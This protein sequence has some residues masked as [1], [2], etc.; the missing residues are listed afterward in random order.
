VSETAGLSKDNV[1]TE[2]PRVTTTVSRPGDGQR[3]PIAHRLQLGRFSG[4]YVWAAFIVIYGIWIPR[5]FLTVTTLQSVAANDA[6]VGIV[7]LGVVVALA[8]GAFDLSFATTVS[9]ASVIDGSMMAQSHVSPVPAILL[10][11]LAGAVVGAVNG[12]LVTRV[13][14]SSI[15]ATL[16]TSSLIQA[17]IDRVTN[18][19][20]FISGFPASF[21][22]LASHR[23]LGIP[24]LFVYLVIFAFIFWY[25]LEHS[26][27]GRRL[28]A[29]GAG[30]DAARLAGVKTGRMVFIG[31]MA[32]SVMAAVAG[33][34]VTAQLGSVT[35]TIG[36]GYLIPVFAAVLL[37]TTQLKVGR[38]NVWGA[39][40]AI[41]LLATGAK[42]LQLAGGQG[43]VTDAFNGAALL[44]AVSLAVLGQRK[45]QGVRRAWPILRRRTRAQTP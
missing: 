19:G 31:L 28:Q 6:I 29:T 1:T 45:R 11:L 40:L 2:D 30:P 41:Y 23:P 14:I 34:L 8:A 37:G 15:A 5:T 10:T 16:G 42:G 21:T 4:L 7:A 17:I 3:T 33:V 22:G 9:M 26:P 13:G 12:L 38:Y 20:Q 18:G 36:A 24:I 39:M 44:I 27:V 43:W 25:F 32:S 35:P